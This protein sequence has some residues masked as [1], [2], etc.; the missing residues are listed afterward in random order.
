[1]VDSLGGPRV[2]VKTRPYPGLGQECIL[3]SF[4]GGQTTPHD[5]PTTKTEVEDHSDLGRT[6]QRKGARS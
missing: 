6:R 3:E 2:V 1:V 4:R 5:K